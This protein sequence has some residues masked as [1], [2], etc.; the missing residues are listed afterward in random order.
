MRREKNLH[1][2]KNNHTSC[3][4]AEQRAGVEKLRGVRFIIHKQTVK[5]FEN[6]LPSETLGKNKKKFLFEN[7]VV[8]LN[9]ALSCSGLNCD[10]PSDSVTQTIIETFTPL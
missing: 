1:K 7:H 3:R 9:S 6:I 5:F 4:L 2:K 8:L 10:F